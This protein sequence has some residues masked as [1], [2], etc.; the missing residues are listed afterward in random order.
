MFLDS[1]WSSGSTS[2]LVSMITLCHWLNV[3]ISLRTPMCRNCSTTSQPNNGAHSKIRGTGDRYLTAKGKYSM[4]RN[5]NACYIILCLNFRRNAAY[6]TIITQKSFRPCGTTKSISDSTAI[7]SRMFIHISGCDKKKIVI[8]WVCTFL[9][10]LKG[11]VLL[12]VNV[13]MLSILSPCDFCGS[14]PTWWAV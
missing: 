9:H 2:V 14:W 1:K 8:R 4:F 3:Q 12:I 13:E 11:A 6:N 5:L 7:L 10:Y